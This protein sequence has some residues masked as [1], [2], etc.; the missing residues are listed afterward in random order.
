MPP[1][2]SSARVFH[3]VLDTAVR[4]HHILSPGP[5]C[6][7]HTFRGTTSS[8]GVFTRMVASCVTDDFI[9]LTEK[10]KENFDVE[11]RVKAIKIP[12]HHCNKYLKGMSKYVL[13]VVI[14]WWELYDFCLYLCRYLLSRPNTRRIEK[15]QD[16]E[17]DMRLLLLAEDLM[18]A[19]FKTCVFHVHGGTEMT[20]D[21]LIEREHYNLIDYNVKIGYDSM[22]VTEVLKHYLP[23]GTEIPSSFEAI[24]HIA[25]VNLRD[26]V[27]PFKYLI[28]QVILDKNPTIKTVVNKVGTITS[29]FRVFDMEVLAGDDETVTEVKQH[30]MRFKLDFRK[31]YW[32]SRLEKEH[33]RLIEEWVKPQDVLVDAMA[34]IGPFAIPAA[35]RGS[36]VHANDLNP[37]SYEWLVT[38]TKLNKVNV[39]C[40]N[41]DGRA[42]MKNAVKGKLEGQS[43]KP[44]FQHMIMNLPAT[45]IEFLDCLKGEFDSD[46][47]DDHEMP[48]VHVYSFLPD[49]ETY[50]G[51]YDSFH[52]KLLCYCQRAFFL[53]M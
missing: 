37:D 19:D 21:Q 46:L 43:E 22:T 18:P 29:E 15:C 20:L 42:F 41:Q 31:V 45:A 12:K 17:E 9:R 2:W 23:D 24:G 50:T 51:M 32:N 10:E 3:R 6:I 30:G 11:I 39:H 53:Y 36:I 40:Y 7:P 1:L 5:S 35:K 34:G 48:F 4:S 8:V 25:H 28:G 44:I 16:G 47:W 49:T 14:M 27:L 26:P 33:T 13:P 38:N 52:K